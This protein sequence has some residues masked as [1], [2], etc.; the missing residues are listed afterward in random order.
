LPTGTASWRAAIILRAAVA[1]RDRAGS[2]GDAVLDEIEAAIEEVRQLLYG[3]AV[4]R[5]D[6]A[7]EAGAAGRKPAEQQLLR[8][9]R[10]SVIGAVVGVIL[11]VAGWSVPV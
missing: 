1:Q 8:M 11:E 9:V 4:G 6:R 2:G 3:G 10:D 5:L 7:L